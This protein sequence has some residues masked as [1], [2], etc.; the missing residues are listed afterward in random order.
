M[1]RKA[2]LLL[3]VQSLPFFKGG[4]GVMV[5]EFYLSPLEVEIQ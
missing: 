3:I 5:S 4:R 1:L 2:N